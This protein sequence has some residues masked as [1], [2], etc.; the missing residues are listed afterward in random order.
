[1][2]DKYTMDKRDVILVSWLRANARHNLRKLS[3]VTNIPV[4]T[5]YDRIKDRA[6]GIITR[7]TVLIDWAALGFGTRALIFLRTDK[8]R[9]NALAEYLVRH[10]RVNGVW[11]VNNGWD[12]LVEGMFHSMREVEEFLDQ[13]EHRY[14]C[15]RNE[16]HYVIEEIC[17][18]NVLRD[19]TIAELALQEL[20][21]YGIQ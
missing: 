19:P 2:M 13:L 20:K 12:F 6:G 21:N 11:R 8:A 16:V 4:S 1:M 15:K 14:G 18:E 9:K 3:R 7:F 5:V 17:R 10:L